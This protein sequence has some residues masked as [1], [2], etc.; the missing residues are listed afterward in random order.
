VYYGDYDL[1]KRILIID[2]SEIDRE[3]LTGILNLGGYEVETAENGYEGLEVILRGRKLIDCIMLDLHM[4]IM[5]GFSVLEI[6]KQNDVKIPVVIVTAESTSD[7]LMKTFPYNIAD[8][9]CK[10]YE[11]SLIWERLENILKKY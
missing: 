8:F 10:P 9:I 7:N 3:I 4:P 2:D 5:N 6:L 11:P 1:E